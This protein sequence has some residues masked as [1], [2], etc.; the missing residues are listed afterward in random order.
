MWR[1]ASSAPMIVLRTMNIP[2]RP[3]LQDVMAQRAATGTYASE[4]VQ[5][6]ARLVGTHDEGENRRS[7]SKVESRPCRS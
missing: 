1:T 5:A 4:I 3:E 2:V 6:G 7:A